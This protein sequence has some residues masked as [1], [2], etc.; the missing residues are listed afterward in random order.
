MSQQADPVQEVAHHCNLCTTVPE[1]NALI[2][3]FY[4]AGQR[5]TAAHLPV[6]VGNFSFPGWQQHRPFYIRICEKCKHLFLGHPRD[7]DNP[8]ISCSHCGRDHSLGTRPQ[9]DTIGGFAG[10]EKMSRK[11]KD[12][13]M[14]HF[15]GD[16]VLGILVL[17]IRLGCVTL[18]IWAVARL[19]GLYWGS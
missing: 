2:M 14:A 1:G 19:I 3:P 12:R 18:L 10:S 15:S 13:L 7:M 5:R 6:F 16:A 8:N 17:L 11:F 4:T 9:Q